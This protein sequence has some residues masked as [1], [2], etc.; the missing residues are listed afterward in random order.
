MGSFPQFDWTEFY[1]DVE[2]AIPVDLPESLGKD[3]DVHMMC[4]SDHAWDKRTRC[5]F[6]G[7]LILCNM[8]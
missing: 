5:S 3:V 8:A 7:F 6:T 4:D 2:E 1:G